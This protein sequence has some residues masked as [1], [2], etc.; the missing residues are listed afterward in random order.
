M[1][2]LEPENSDYAAYVVKLPA[3]KTL[4]G[5]DNLVGLQVLG[6]QA[7]VAK[8]TDYG[9]LALVFT[10][11]TQLSQEFAYENNL[12]RHSDRNKNQD[13]TGYLEDNRHIRSMQLRGHRS[14]ALVMR[15]SAL[16]Y[17][18]KLD[19][20]QFNEGD[21]FDRIGDHEICQKFISKKTRAQQTMEKNKKVFSRVDEKFMP[22]H[23]KTD[24]F[25]KNAHIIPENADVTV[26][27]KLHGTSIRVGHTIV[28]R[29]LKL[30]DKLAKRM[31]VKVH[32]KEYD[33]IYASR[34]AIKDK[35]NPGAQ[36]FYESDVWALN[37]SKLDGLLPQGYLVYG[38][39]V[40]WTPEGGNLQARYTYNVPHGLADL[41]VY[42]IAVMNPEGVVV[43]L[44]YDQ[45]VE[46]CRDRG[47]K[48]VPLLWRG[49]YKDFDWK[50][51]VDRFEEKTLHKYHE[52][53]HANAI[54]LS[55]DSMCDEGVVI[56]AEGLAP[57][58]LKCKSET[59][60][61][62]DNKNMAE[63]VLDMEEEGKIENG[64][65]A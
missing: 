41:Y 19:L 5:L 11:G 30:A 10:K 20:S 32:D 33:M 64:E 44:T 55:K 49:K 34:R 57:Y 46:F 14:S 28:A 43:D 31:G 8:D 16:S 52:E 3:P 61:E 26:T 53:G 47:I 39:L 23:Y 60:D 48:V 29:K 37:G 18:K 62:F 27:Q 13:E 58:T 35:N 1:K 9:D 45:I 24:S 2:L 65:S 63:G 38:E 15:L 51:W 56:R 25:F 54:P 36:H 21:K 22:E 50:E 17:I 59:F 7:L 4:E 42:R 40:G 12:H 6:D